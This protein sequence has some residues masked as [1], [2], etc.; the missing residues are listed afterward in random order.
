V[1]RGT[2]LGNP[3][4]LAWKDGLLVATMGTG[5]IYRLDAQGTRTAVQHPP[6]GQ[7]DGL[8]GDGRLVVTSWETG[9]IFVGQ[10]DHALEAL[11]TQLK[12]PADLG[13]D[14]RRQRLLIPVLLDNQLRI[15]SLPEGTTRTP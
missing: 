13:L 14:T 15:V 9:V 5:D 12:G 2:S 8:L 3:N 10:E 1:A 7:L 6:E 4:G 11:A